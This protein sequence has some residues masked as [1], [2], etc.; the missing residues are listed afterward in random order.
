MLLLSPK[1]G[2]CNFILSAKIKAHFLGDKRS[3]NHNTNKIIK[4]RI[5]LMKMLSRNNVVV[6]VHIFCW[7]ILGIGVLYYIPSTW[8]VPVPAEFWIKQTILLVVLMGVFYLNVNLLIP[9]LLI[10]QKVFTYI[11]V[12]SI[13]VVYVEG[14]KDYAKI[15]LANSDK[16]VLSLITLKSLEEKLPKRK[17][18]RIHKSFIISLDKITSVTKNAVYIADFMLSVSDQYKDEFARFIETWR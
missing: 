12:A 6:L 2:C 3:I 8:G 13:L 1:N 14:L 11:A 7:L 15:H 10:K 18:M 9:N 4:F 17:F 5:P 16:S